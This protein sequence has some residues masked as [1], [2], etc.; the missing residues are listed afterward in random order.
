V[1]RGE[2]EKFGVPNIHEKSRLYYCSCTLFYTSHTLMFEI[3]LLTI[4]PLVQAGYRA[5][6]VS[7]D[8][9]NEMLIRKRNPCICMYFFHCLFFSY[10]VTDAMFKN[11]NLCYQINYVLELFNERTL[12]QQSPS[13]RKYYSKKDA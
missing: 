1:L 3:I 6:L 8:K 9:M 10:Y 11:L 12:G 5:Y 4:P 13:V 7:I 2:E